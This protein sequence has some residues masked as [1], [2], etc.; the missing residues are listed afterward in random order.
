M[1]INILPAGTDPEHPDIKPSVS[2]RPPTIDLN[3]TVPSEEPHTSSVAPKPLPTPA[4]GSVE[5]PESGAEW[6]KKEK[7]VE[8]D[9]KAGVNKAEKKGKEYAK[10]AKAELHEAESKLEPYWE[11]TKDV[12]LRPGTLGGLMGVGKYP[13]ARARK[14]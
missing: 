6:E 2:P 7:K 11:K 5:L 1:Q 3:P 12:V 13:L 10:K 8:K 4:K 14:V 9:V